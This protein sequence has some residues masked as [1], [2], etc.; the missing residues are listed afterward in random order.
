MI[1]TK[2]LL[3]QADKY[4]SFFSFGS[5]QQN[6]ANEREEQGEIEGVIDSMKCRERWW[7][8]WCLMMMM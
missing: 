7:E 5:N 4:F 6:W 1:Y 3:S 8:R 2:H